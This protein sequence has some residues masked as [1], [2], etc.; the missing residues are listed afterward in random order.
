MSI[1]WR[2]RTESRME[3][4]SNSP[5]RMPNSQACEGLA[6]TLLNVQNLTVRYP[7]KGQEFTAIHDVSFAIAPGEIVGLLGESGCGK[8]TTALSLLRVLPAAARVA[9]GSI[10]FQGSDLLLLKESQLRKIRGA[11][12]A[13]IYQDSSVLNPV[14]QVGAQ[15]SEVL[16]AHAKCTARDARDRVQ[17]IFTSIGLTDSDRIYKAYPH[18][19]SGGQRQ[20]IAIAQALVCNPRIVIADE[21]TA[22]VDPDTAAEIL[23]CMRHMQESFNTSF[24]FVSHDPDL[25]AT[26]ADRVLVMYAGEIVEEGPLSEVYS[27]PFHPYTEALLQCSLKHAPAREYDQVRHLPFIPGNSPDPFE[28]CAG[29][30]FADRCQD[31]MPICDTRPERFDISQARSARCFKCEV[32]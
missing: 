7:V 20:R 25:L 23:Q 27:G 15:V 28:T 9:A 2:D 13:L 6:E 4:I 5:V 14:M 17:H 26:V 1:D 22:S 32:T 8:T 3:V 21:P 12:I 24:L 19:L 11:E 10:F 29:C 30:S 31:R 18:Q 16:R